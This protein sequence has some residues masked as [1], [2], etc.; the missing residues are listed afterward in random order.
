MKDGVNRD[1]STGKIYLNASYVGI[2]LYA[3][4]AK[5]QYLGAG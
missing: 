2:Y 4:G 5:T 1:D 3:A